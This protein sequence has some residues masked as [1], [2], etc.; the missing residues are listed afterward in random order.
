[1]SHCP[2]I[3]LLLPICLFVITTKICFAENPHKDRLPTMLPFAGE[4]LPDSN[5]VPVEFEFHHALS[6]GDSGVGINGSFNGWGDVFKCQN[7]GGDK[8]IVVLYLAPGQYQYK[9]VTYIDTVGQ[10]SKI[11]W[12]LSRLYLQLMALIFPT[13]GI[14][15]IQKRI[16]LAIFHQRN[17]ISVPIVYCSRSQIVRVQPYRVPQILQY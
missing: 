16:D 8:W 14:T 10:P 4:Q 17:W 2:K 9:F 13:P 1:M 3:I 12:F 15:S 6:P 11:H 7:V 5:L